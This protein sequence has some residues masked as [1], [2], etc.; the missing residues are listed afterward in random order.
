MFPSFI[1]FWWQEKKR[2]LLPCAI[3]LLATALFLSTSSAFAFEILVLKSIDAK[4]YDLVL[5][6]LTEVVPDADLRI[7]NMS[8]DLKKGSKIIK[9]LQGLSPGLILAL[10]AKAAWVSKDV[11][12]I[13]VA[14]SM[15]TNPENY[16]LENV[17]GIRLNFPSK[18]YL[19]KAKEIM[20]KLKKIG[21][22]FSSKNEEK[23]RK[24]KTIA[25]S[26]GIEIIAVKISSLSKLSHS[27]D[28]LVPK[29]GAIWIYNDPLVT[30]KPKVIKEIIILRTLRQRKPLIG[31][32]KWSVKQ[33]ALF[34]LFS[35]YKN[36]GKQTGRLVQQIRQ[37]NVVE[38]ESPDDIQTLFN[39]KV[40]E[41]ISS[42]TVIKVPRNV[43]FTSEK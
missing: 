18:L 9:T 32:N 22:I 15:V 33:G 8:G 3:S 24:T 13:P 5:E 30:S 29:V 43:F 38:S 6:G 26:M 7:E 12:G 14:Y 41:R 25:K 27:L 19:E 11:Q 20:P 34:C 40:M 2:H 21:I 17:A 16:K 28:E 37:G 36:I 23:I 10:G 1:Y 35:D 42:T 4:P 39:E 31:L